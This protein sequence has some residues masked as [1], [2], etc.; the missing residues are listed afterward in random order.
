MD[1][2]PISLARA[3]DEHPPGSSDEDE[4]DDEGQGADSQGIGRRGDADEIAIWG[5]D[6]NLAG[7]DEVPLPLQIPSG[8]IHITSSRVRRLLLSLQPQISEATDHAAAWCGLAAWRYHATGSSAH[9]PP[10]QLQGFF[11]DSYVRQAAQH[12]T[13]FGEEI[14]C[15]W[16]RG[17]RNLGAAQSV[18]VTAF[19]SEE[20]EGEGFAEDFSEEDTGVGRGGGG[21]LEEEAVAGRHR[22]S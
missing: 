6:D 3:D 8:C 20:E 11:L 19:S 13:A 7:G 16:N 12:E 17:S 5:I 18:V 10:L 21:D 15:G 14:L 4:S 2:V 22:C 1:E 9:T